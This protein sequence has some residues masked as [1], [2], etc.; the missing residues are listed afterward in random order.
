MNA[1]QTLY[2]K[3]LKE[4]RGVVLF[5][6]AAALCLDGYALVVAFKNSK[7]VPE[8]ALVGVPYLMALV[9]PF[10]LVHS[11]TQEFR[12]QTHYL[13]LSLP[14]PRW[15][16]VLSKY[17]AILTGSAAL[18][19]LATAFL[20]AVFLSL[21]SLAGS[22]PQVRVSH[23]SGADLWILMASGYF[24][25]TVLLLGVATLITGVRLMVRRFQGIL[26]ALCFGACMYVYGRLLEPVVSRLDFLGTYELTVVE[27]LSMSGSEEIQHVQPELQVLVYSCVMGLLFLGLGTWLIDRR[28]EA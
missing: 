16:L 24:S 4:N 15:G 11:F 28:V 22:D 12:G 8:M 5:L 2:I 27:R 21:T 7:L 19:L 25:I 23:V 26:S 14:V 20:H 13:L 9:F 1:W 18:F 6:L 10:L 3:E 17:A